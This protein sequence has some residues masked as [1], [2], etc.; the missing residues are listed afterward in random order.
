MLKAAT[1]FA[2]VTA[3]VGVLPDNTTML[4][5]GLSYTS[6]WKLTHLHIKCL[7][8]VSALRAY[9]SS[10]QSALLTESEAAKQPAH[11]GSIQRDSEK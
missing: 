3:H 10:N 11:T 5:T 4:C 2:I 8:L 1:L 7:R 9:E 6:C